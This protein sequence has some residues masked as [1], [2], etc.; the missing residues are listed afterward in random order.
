MRRGPRRQ[1]SNGVS[2]MDDDCMWLRGSLADI[3]TATI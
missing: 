2:E 1:V 3:D